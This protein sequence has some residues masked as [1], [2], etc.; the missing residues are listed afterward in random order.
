MA[1]GG[2]GRWTPQH[3][4]GGGQL[5]ASTPKRRKCR[6]L[7]LGC[8]PSR[9]TDV[10]KCTRSLV[11]KREKTVKT[12]KPERKGLDAHGRGGGSGGEDG[13][14]EPGSATDA[15]QR[16]LLVQLRVSPAPWLAVTAM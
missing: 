6:R 13:P 5:P 12:A 9:K 3:V 1:G 2:A 7:S 14:T 10:R 4:A 15:S 11:G 16:H 8:G